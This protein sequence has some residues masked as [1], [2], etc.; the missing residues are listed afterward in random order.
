MKEDYLHQEVEET[1]H[2]EKEDVVKPKKAAKKEK[3]TAAD[4]NQ[5]TKRTDR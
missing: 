2:V 5:G 3:K 1:E 4:L